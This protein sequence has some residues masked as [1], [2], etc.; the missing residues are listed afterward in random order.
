M[1]EN[2]LDK[3]EVAEGAEGQ[4]KE[5]SPTEAD[6]WANPENLSK[7]A[8]GRKRLRGCGQVVVSGS[9][10]ILGKSLKMSESLFYSFLCVSVKDSSP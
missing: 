1:K 4:I 5:D 7:S 2:A 6:L 9:G 3:T 8:P 10:N